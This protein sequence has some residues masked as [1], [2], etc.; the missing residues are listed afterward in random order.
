MKIELAVPQKNISLSDI[1]QPVRNE[2]K[3]FEKE[4]AKHIQSDVPFLKTIVNYLLR[5]KG[6]QVR[7]LFTLLSAGM[8]GSINSK[9][10]IA[11]T[12]IEMLHTATLVH[13]DVVDESFQRRNA[14]TINALW[15]TKVAVLM[16]DYLLSRG[17][18]TALNTNNHDLLQIVSSAV[19]EMSEGEL[20]QLKK[21]RKLN[22]TKEEYFD[23]IRKKTASLIASCTACGTA[24]V[25]TDKQVI[26]QMR[27]FGYLT[28]IVFQ[29]KDDL[30]DYTSRKKTGKPK[31]NDLKDKKI[32]LPLIYSLDKSSTEVKKEMLQLISKPKDPSHSYERIKDFISSTGGFIYTEK[33][34]MAYK[35]KAVKILE[36]YPPSP[37]L[38]S[39]LNLLDFII[40]RKK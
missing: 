24:S 11:A 14:F 10:Y 25:V 22:I 31:G 37:Y 39:M 18:L 4:F 34:M 28:G 7:P 5:N 15:G 33:S 30:L 32:T 16:G 6:K 27:E 23:I 3:Q 2:L 9:T 26:N 8:H 19:Q 17:L 29:I 12:L 21:S 40:H 36:T 38:D 35:D 20:M 1:K 13:D